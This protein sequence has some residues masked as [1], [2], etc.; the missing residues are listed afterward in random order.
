[1]HWS[2]AQNF[3]LLRLVGSFWLIFSVCES[4]FKFYIEKTLKKVGKSRILVV[5]TNPKT[6]PKCFPNRRPKKHAIFRRFSLEKCLVAQV[7]TS[8]L[9]WFL[10]YFLLVG[11]FSSN[12]CLHAFLV[13]KTFQNPLQNLSRTLSKSMPKT[14]CFLISVFWGFG[15]DLKASWA[16][17]LEPSWLKIVKKTI[18]CALPSFLKLDVF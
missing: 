5:Q 13:R 1:M 6:V 2:P 18:G 16:S 3:C 7:P 9:Y 14:C 10:Q 11:H 17:N 8:I 15:L 12:R 4:Q